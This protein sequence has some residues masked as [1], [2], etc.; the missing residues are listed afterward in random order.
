MHDTGLSSVLVRILLVV[1][2]H[3]KSIRVRESIYL[4][5]GSQRVMGVPQP[6]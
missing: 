4:Q 3:G 1:P 5:T 2:H 6:L